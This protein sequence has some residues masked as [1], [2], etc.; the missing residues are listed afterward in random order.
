MLFESPLKRMRAHILKMADAAIEAAGIPITLTPA[1]ASWG[2]MVNYRGNSK[3]AD[4]MIKPWYRERRAEI[5]A[6]MPFVAVDYLHYFGCAV[7]YEPDIVEG[8]GARALHIA[9]TLLAALPMPGELG[10][11]P[12]AMLWYAS[13]LR[14]IMLDALKVDAKQLSAAPAAPADVGVGVVNHEP[15]LEHG[16]RRDASLDSGVATAGRCPLHSLGDIF[17]T[18]RPNRPVTPATP[19]LAKFCCPKPAICKTHVL[20][21]ATLFFQNLASSD[22][23]APPC[24]FA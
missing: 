23:A 10:V 22:L 24:T 12:V 11:E 2:K 17:N 19:F 3:D 8:D 5:D 6:S 4:A 13:R 15:G 20:D 1:R 9:R 7:V 21:G 16:R 18:D 14:R